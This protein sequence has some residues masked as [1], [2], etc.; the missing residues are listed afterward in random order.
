MNEMFEKTLVITPHLDD[1]TIGAGGTIH[2]VLESGNSVK[3]VVVGTPSEFYSVHQG[4][5]VDTNERYVSF[6][7]AM[8]ILGVDDIVT[9]EGYP[10]ASMDTMPLLKLVSD[11]DK[12]IHDYRPTAVLFPYQSHHQ[13]HKYVNEATVAALR[14]KAESRF[15]KLKAMYEY[16]YITGFNQSF[17]PT[18]KLY[19][20]LGD[21]DVECKKKALNCYDSQLNRGPRDLLDKSAIMDLLRTRGRE[22][23]ELNA[24]VFYPISISI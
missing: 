10:E 15:I 22:V 9:L 2:R 24:E 19:V 3:V 17:I 18:S 16:P 21:E 14:P 8:S 5:I 7:K 11:L 13:D 12:I 23:G 1:E 6:R 20:T 4:G